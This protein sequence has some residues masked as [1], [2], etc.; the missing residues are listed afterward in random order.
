[1][2][3]PGLHLKAGFC[4]IKKLQHNGDSFLGKTLS[5]TS[6]FEAAKYDAEV[7]KCGRSTSQK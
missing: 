3:T 4:T 1:M 6:L 2:N 5:S 7:F